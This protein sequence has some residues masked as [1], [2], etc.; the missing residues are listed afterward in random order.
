MPRKV[1]WGLAPPQGAEEPAAVA[2][3]APA[4]RTGPAV[5]W[6]VGQAGAAFVYP[7]VPVVPGRPFFT[8]ADANP[9]QSSTMSRSAVVNVSNYACHTDTVE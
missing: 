7:E 4:P 1:G 3:E 8:E 5:T 6:Q 2:A 9:P